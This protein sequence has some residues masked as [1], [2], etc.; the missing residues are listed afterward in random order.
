[1]SWSWT[2]YKYLATQFLLGVAIVHGAFLMLAF[3]IDVVDI[4]NRTAGRNITSGVIV[5]MAL[6]QLPDLGQELLPFSVLLGGVFAFA[7]LSRN[8]ELVATRAAGMSAWDF[9]L[10]PLS[11]AVLLGIFQVMVFTPVS[12]QMLAQ[13]AALEAKY[14]RGE[15]SQLAVSINGLWLR[16]GDETHQSVIHALR[17]AH[18]GVELEDV[19]VFRY[20]A[21]DHFLGRIGA[22]SASLEAQAWL[23]RDANVSGLDGVVSHFARYELPTS[24]TPTQ[25]QE[26][27]ASPNTLSFWE[28]PGFIRAAQNA[29]FAATRHELYFCT[30]LALP[31]LFAAMVFMAASFSVRLQRGGGVARMILVSALSGFAIYFF[32]DLTR[33]LGQSGILPVLI[34]ATAPALA[35]ILI[36]M[37]LVFHQED[38]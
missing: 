17:V 13:F 26:S 11:V 22:R 3:S 18:Q 34:A 14:I 8:Q 29:G 15:E 36:G 37:T 16:Q 35:A 10:P 38:G 19:D 9:L 32:S 25:I 28:L 31:V 2:L 1:M 12:A 27:F 6:L 30:L 5:G 23:L 7:R 21:H 33:A 20:A 24:M 4:I